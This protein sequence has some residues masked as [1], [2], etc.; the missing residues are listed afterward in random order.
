[1]M[2]KEASEENILLLFK[3]AWPDFPKGKLVK[4]ESPDFILRCSRKTSIGIELT[5]L[6]G[7]DLLRNYEDK[8]PPDAGS[9]QPKSDQSRIRITWKQISSTIRRKEEKLALYRRQMAESY[10]LII[11]AGEENE[12]RRFRISQ[13]VVQWHFNTQFNKVFL[14]I[15]PEKKVI[16]FE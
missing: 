4:S 1:M 13:N 15:L 5:R 11:T 3:E 7:Q 14:F 6:D 9:Y 12:R 8:T 16:G 10:W 2:N